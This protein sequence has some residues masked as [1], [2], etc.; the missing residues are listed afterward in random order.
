VDERQLG[1][2]PER[3]YDLAMIRKEKLDPSWHKARVAARIWLKAQQGRPLSVRDKRLA[4]ALADDAELDNGLIHEVAC[5]VEAGQFA[6][7]WTT[8]RTLPKA[9]VLAI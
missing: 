4:R 3:C 2:L 8:A 9:V 5:Q 7:L 6:R 1:K